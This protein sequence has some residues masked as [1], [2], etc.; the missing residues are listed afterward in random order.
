LREAGII[1][2]YPAFQHGVFTYPEIATH[3]SH[4]DVSEAL[5]AI[6]YEQAIKY[7]ALD[8]A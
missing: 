3:W 5:A 2:I 4:D 6:K 7:S 1:Q 8:D